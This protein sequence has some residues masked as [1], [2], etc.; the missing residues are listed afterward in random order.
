MTPVAAHWID[1]S[2]G[3]TRVT[4]RAAAHL[5]LES[6]LARLLPLMSRHSGGPVALAPADRSIVSL[7]ETSA[8]CPS[9][10]FYRASL[11][12]LLTLS[13]HVS[14]RGAGM[15]SSRGQSRGQVLSGLYG[16]ILG[17]ALPSSGQ[18]DTCGRLPLR[19]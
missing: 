5:S 18:Q 1:I 8:G 14:R 19:L 17:A 12:M 6:R 10:N 15:S 11:L 3:C 4:G 16:G 13:R 7:P 9:T 2:I